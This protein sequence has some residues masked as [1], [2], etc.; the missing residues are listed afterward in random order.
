MII[1]Y[2][3][4]PPAQA[5][6]AMSF[7]DSVLLGLHLY[8]RNENPGNRNPEIKNGAVF[9]RAIF[10]FNLGISYCCFSFPLGGSNFFTD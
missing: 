5:F 6:D 3:S 2:P 9:D 8:P 10:R 4:V 1:F 7:G